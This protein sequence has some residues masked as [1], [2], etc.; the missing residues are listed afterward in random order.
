MV[1]PEWFPPLERLLWRSFKTLWSWSGFAPA[2]VAVTIVVFVSRLL[3]RNRDA[4]KRRY[5]QFSFGEFLKD[6]GD[7]LRPTITGWTTILTLVLWALCYGVAIATTVYQ[8]HNELV[9]QL[10][11]AKVERRNKTSGPS[12]EDAAAMA[13]RLKVAEVAA[14]E[15]AQDSAYAD[16]PYCRRL[17]FQTDREINPVELLIF[18]SGPLKYANVYGQRIGTQGGAEI[19]K[20]DT[21]RITVSVKGIG[22]PLLTPSMPL[23]I[24][25][26]SDN[27]FHLL[28]F[29]RDGAQ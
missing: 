10:A 24:R 20:R 8:Q 13:R 23:V 14:L 7:E 4:H 27:E 3:V 16:A 28:K 11:Q 9:A 22:E 5:R 25:A 26:C 6:I 12:S 19:D 17:I 15:E 21:S 1:A 2:A 18:L 29:V